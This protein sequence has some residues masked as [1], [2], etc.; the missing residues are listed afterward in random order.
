MM[1]I[2]ELIGKY[3]HIHSNVCYYFELVSVDKYG[4]KI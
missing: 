2:H 1:I 4:R 3:A